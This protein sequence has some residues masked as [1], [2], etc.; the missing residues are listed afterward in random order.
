MNNISSH[1]S[2]SEVNFD[3]S[4]DSENDPEMKNRFVYRTDICTSKLYMDYLHYA[5]DKLDLFN[6][7]LDSVVN[8]KFNI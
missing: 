3:D 8:K 1:K 5:H 4:N 6:L 7:I 2:I